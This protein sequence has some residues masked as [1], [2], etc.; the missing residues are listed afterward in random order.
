MARNNYFQ[1]KQFRIIQEQSAMKV[2]VDGVLL[3]AWAD[4]ACAGQILDVGTGTGLIALMMAQKNNSSQ[5]DA[6]EIEPEA[7]QEALLNV[8]QTQW[9]E[10]IQLECCSFQEFI[11]RT[12][13]KYDLIVSNPPFFTNGH[14]APLEN[15]AQARHS[16]SLPLPVLI[17]G[18]K[19]LLNENG[20]I[21]L[22]LPVE[23]LSEIQQLAAS[24]KLCISRLCRVKPNPQ[25]PEFRILIEL[26]NSECIVQEENLMIEFEKHFDYTP[27]YKALTKNFYLKF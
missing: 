4:A 24:E 9:S 11:D 6:I 20:K 22:V 5:I 12:N 16:D 18:A 14:K 3:G 8:Q 10:R 2:G 26:T 25:K 27:E 19:G 15:R 23:S 21:A 1:F 17:S 7:F 13:R